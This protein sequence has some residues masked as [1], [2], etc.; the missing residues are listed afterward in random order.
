MMQWRWVV[1]WECGNQ[2]Q[3]IQF[4]TTIN[5]ECGNELINLPTR[6]STPTHKMLAAP[7]RDWGW[8]T[9]LARDIWG[10]LLW[11]RRSSPCHLTWR[12]RR[13]CQWSVTLE[14]PAGAARLARGRLSRAARG[15]TGRCQF[16]AP[17]RR[18]ARGD[19]VWLE[20]WVCR[21]HRVMSDP[22]G[23]PYV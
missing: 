20:R 21:R 22:N 16:S 6:V 19:T 11:R 8:Q 17:H 15:F 5:R 13:R 14:F 1:N 10:A 2:H 23:M 18:E 9:P 7:K 12:A 4:S 3:H